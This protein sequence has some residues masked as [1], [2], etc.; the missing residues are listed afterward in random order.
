MRVESRAQ[1]QDAVRV[2][3][4]GKK[5]RFESRRQQR[6]AVRSRGYSKGPRFE[7]AAGGHR[8]AVRSCKGR[9]QGDACDDGGVGGQLDVAQPERWLR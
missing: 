3:G 6:A 7:V 2:A 8:A 9:S 4:A 5:P 1:V